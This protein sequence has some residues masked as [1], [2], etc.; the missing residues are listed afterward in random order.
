MTLLLLRTMR[1][2]WLLLP[3]PALCLRLLVLALTM[4]QGSSHLQS[5]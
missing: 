1:R 3:L 4:L 2:Y 5:P